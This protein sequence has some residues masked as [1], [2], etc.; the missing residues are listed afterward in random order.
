MPTTVPDPAGVEAVPSV[1]VMTAEA[2]REIVGAKV[3]DT[4]QLAPA[5]SAVKQ[6]LV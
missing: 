3:T 6:V 1:T 2:L 5:A 4:V